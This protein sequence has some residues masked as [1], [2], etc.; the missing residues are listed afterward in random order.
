SAVTM[1]G[2]WTLGHWGWLRPPQCPHS[3][4]CIQ[5]ARA[6]EAC[7]QRCGRLGLDL[8][9]AREQLLAAEAERS[10]LDVR[11]QHAR[12]QVRVEMK[13]RHR[14]EAELEKQVRSL[15]PVLGRDCWRV[16]GSGTG[17]GGAPALAAADWGAWL[18]GR[19][20]GGFWAGLS[21]K[22]GTES[23]A[24]NWLTQA[25]WWGSW[26]SPWGPSQLV[27]LLKARTGASRPSP[28]GP[29]GTLARAT[30]SPCSQVTPQ[31]HPPANLGMPPALLVPAGGSRPVSSP[32]GLWGAGPGCPLTPPFLQIIRPE[33]CATC[34]SRARFGR[35]ALR[36]RRCRLEGILADFAP[37]TVPRVPALVVQCVSEVERRGLT[38]AGLYRVPG[39]EPLV[40][41]WKQKLL[42]AKGAAPS[43]GRVAD[44]HVVCG[45][46][47]DFLRGLRE[48][49]VTFRLHPAFLQAADI[50][51]E[52]A[53]QAALAHLVNELPQANRDTLAFLM[54]HLLRVT[55]SP[56]CKM[57]RLNLARVFG[58]T[59]VGH[60]SACP[61]PLA[62][63]E[64]TPQ[65]CKV[66]AVRHQP[67]GGWR[68]SG[69]WGGVLC[70]GPPPQF[71][72]T[73]ASDKM[74]LCPRKLMRKINVFLK[75]PQDSLVLLLN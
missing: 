31:Y 53:S 41:E 12:N 70:P 37:P 5:V 11:L 15:V 32:R 30:A 57:D 74:G 22:Q 61:T 21:Q 44:V 4:D 46:L 6:F 28:W 24:W 1:A 17:E 55:H 39:A 25:G 54:L 34:G 3:P 66:G 65:Q 64:D 52:A 68:C 18:W 51:D 50:P 27:P 40:R 9:R 36:C 48:P 10:A 14:A 59:L 2:P 69:G 33:S 47:K 71:F 49:L 75:V 8:R 58:P 43:L 56:E 62:I 42:R 7:R 23:P 67:Q 38:E 63:L 60:S 29:A 45:V 16:G 73:L 20:G 35:V 19:R 72:S 13:K 26:V